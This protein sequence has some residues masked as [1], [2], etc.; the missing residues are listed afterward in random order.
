M[1]YKNN[2]VFRT[3]KKEIKDDFI[4][5]KSL[6]ENLNIDKNKIYYDGIHLNKFGHNIYAEII[7]EI[8]KKKN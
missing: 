6:L 5:M 3:L 4:D 8:I 2:K 1:E 7:A